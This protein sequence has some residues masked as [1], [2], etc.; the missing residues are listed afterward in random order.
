MALLIILQKLKPI[1][2]ENIDPVG[3]ESYKY[4]FYR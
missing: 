2:F 3:L 4:K 1:N